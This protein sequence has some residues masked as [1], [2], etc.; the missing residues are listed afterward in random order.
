M[1]KDLKCPNVLLTNKGVL[2]ISD[3]GCSKDFER[4]ISFVNYQAYGSKTQKGTPHWMAPESIRSEFTRFSDIWSL[5]CTVIEMATGEPPW[6]EYKNPMA[7]IYN[8]IKTNTPP[9]LPNNLSSICKNFLQC[10]L[11]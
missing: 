10:C 4:T 3:F 6:N 11:K 8:L 9:E 5:G 2:K 7:A 1:H